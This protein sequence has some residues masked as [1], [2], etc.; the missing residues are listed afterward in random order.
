MNQI[1]RALISVWDKTGIVDIARFLHNNNVEIISTG[2][3]KKILEKEGVPITPV[4]DIT[5]Q[6][7]IMNGRVKTLHPLIFG[8]VL[9]DRNNK[10][11]LIDLKS[12]DTSLIDIVIINLYPF[13]EE[14]VLK[15]M[16]LNKAIEFI[17]IGG[18]SLL[19]AAAKNYQFV[20]P[21][22]S[23]NQYNEFIEL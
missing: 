13:K 7:E 17:D 11:H 5:K 2:G 6:N 14:A 15:K 23:P 16:V 9:A 19:R 3:T 21:L 22:S 1:K 8:G 4:S 20:V 18:P 10:E 12:L